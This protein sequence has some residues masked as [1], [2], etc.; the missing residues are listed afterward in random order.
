MLKGNVEKIMRETDS[1]QIY[2]R[3]R[4]SWLDPHTCSIHPPDAHCELYWYDGYKWPDNI[5][6]WKEFRKTQYKVK[7][8]NLEKDML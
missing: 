4:K 5:R 7:I 8:M 3:A 1:P 6:N 2:K